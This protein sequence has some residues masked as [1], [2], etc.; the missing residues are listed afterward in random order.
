MSPGDFFIVFFIG[1]IFFGGL[2][3]GF[4]L[5]SWNMKDLKEKKKR[6]DHL[7]KN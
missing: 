3:V 5:Y 1:I 7:N 2:Y 6:N 4:K